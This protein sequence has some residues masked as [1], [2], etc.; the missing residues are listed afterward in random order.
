[1]TPSN[2]PKPSDVFGR[3]REWELLI[4]HLV[5]KRAGSQLAIVL[6]RRRQGKSS[7]L[8]GAALATGALYWEAAQQSREQNLAA[9][10]EALGR[11]FG[12]PGALRFSDWTE[13]LAAV[14]SQA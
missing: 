8:D 14:F 10:G 13:A 9:F 1:M 4:D 7:L 6:G 3:Q 5:G 11:H 12:A 2:Y